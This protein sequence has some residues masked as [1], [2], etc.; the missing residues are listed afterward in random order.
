[1]GAR[2]AAE[3]FPPGEFLREELEARGWTQ[4]EFAE[5]IG[6]D[7]RLVSEVIG[8]KRTVTPETAIALGQALETGP[9]LWMNLESQ[10]QLSKVRSYGEES[11]AKKAKLHG[12]FPVREMVKRG[13]IE[14]TKNIELLESQVLSFFGISSIDEQPEFLHAAKKKSY[15]DT[16]ILQLAW[17]SRAKQ[18]AKAAP[19]QKYSESK[20][21]GAIE[22]LRELVEYVDG[23]RSVASILN[24]YGIRFIVVES[25]PG[26]KIDGACFW[27][28]K[29]PVIAMSLR[30][31]RVDNFWHT[32]F[33]ELD[34]V[35][36]KEGMSHPILDVDI[37][38]NDEKPANEIRANDAAAETLVPSKEFEGFIARVSPMFS[39]ESINGFA[40]R[41]RVHPGIV[42]GQLQNRGL[43][44][45][46]F[47]R[48][49]LE[50]IRDFVTSTALTDGFG[51]MLD[52]SSN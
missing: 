43:L 44:P 32:L 52:L 6:K 4:A 39:D 45:W 30:F 16:S 34:H 38:S 41:M 9:E 14:S 22:E 18:L 37:Q 19:A 40:L 50:K 49:K 35:L 7:A 36:H 46:S 24:R 17:L 31:D 26:C 15:D 23:A 47:H 42:V 20:L 48:K 11:I 27:I 1:M 25:L 10:Y 3:V 8:G 28:D 29:S 12:L 33:H 13:W 5:I 21:K 51:R 2:V